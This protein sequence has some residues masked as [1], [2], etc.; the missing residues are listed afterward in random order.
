MYY[1]MWLRFQRAN[2]CNNFDETRARQYSNCIAP[3]SV[4]NN[5]KP[6]ETVTV[7]GKVY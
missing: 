3:C 4:I 6:I 2:L 1:V 5:L 7:S